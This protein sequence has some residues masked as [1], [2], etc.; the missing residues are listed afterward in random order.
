MPLQACIKCY[1]IWDVRKVSFSI[2]DFENLR[3]HN[4]TYV[5]CKDCNNGKEKSVL[6]N[7][8]GEFT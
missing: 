2:V 8:Y 1:R 5:L 7:E 4:Q 6:K 3:Q